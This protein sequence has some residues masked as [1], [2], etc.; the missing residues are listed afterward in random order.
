MTDEQAMAAR[1]Q[2]FIR[3]N[4]SPK[5]RVLSLGDGC[6]CPLCDVD[7]FSAHVASL[8]RQLDDRLKSPCGHWACYAITEDG[9]KHIYCTICQRDAAREALRQARPMLK[10]FSGECGHCGMDE[11]PPEDCPHLKLLAVVDAALQ[12]VPPQPKITL[13]EARLEVERLNEV[14]PTSDAPAPKETK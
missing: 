1:L 8:Q 14:W 7:R 12:S 5:C 4:S 9:G 3:N 6:L 11:L 10:H 2:A 13:A